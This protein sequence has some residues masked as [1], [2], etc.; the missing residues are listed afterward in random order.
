MS[1][2][3]D[4]TQRTDLDGGFRK[5]LARRICQ[6]VDLKILVMK[7]WLGLECLSHIERKCMNLR[8]ILPHLSGEMSRDAE[9]LKETAKQGDTVV[10]N[11]KTPDGTLVTVNAVIKAKYPHVVHMQYQTAKG[12]VVNTS[13]AWKKLLMIML[14]PSSIEDNEEGE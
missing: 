5:K 14:N 8:E 13:F 3:G 6:M 4:Q 11:V 10:L 2:I 1:I 7:L 9:L 12:Y